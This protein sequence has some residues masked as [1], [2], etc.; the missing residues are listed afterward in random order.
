MRYVY[1]LTLERDEDGGYIARTRDVPEANTNGDSEKEALQE[2]SEALGA[3]LAGY[4][5]EGRVIPPPSDALPG[6]YPVPVA[7]LVAVKLALRSAM[8]DE[9]I[10]NVELARRLGVSEGAV[11]RLLDL[12]H[13]FRL[14]VVVTALAAIGRGLIIED[15]EQFAA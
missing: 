12:D 1:S 9:H 5:L 2:M 6:E 13:A 15:Q 4:A 8:H 3:A 10:T 11:R 14:D 7:P